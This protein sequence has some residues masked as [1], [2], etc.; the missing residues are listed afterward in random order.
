MSTG[1]QLRATMSPRN[2]LVRGAI[3]FVKAGLFILGSLI[4]VVLFIPLLV[5]A[6]GATV[7][8]LLWPLYLGA[9]LEY[10]FVPGD[11]VRSSQSIWPEWYLFAFAWIGLLVVGTIALR[12]YRRNVRFRRIRQAALENVAP[13]G[14]ET[15]DVTGI[16]APDLGA[17]VEIDPEEFDPIDGEELNAVDETRPKI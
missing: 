16:D 2:R 15:P 10:G 5:L 9:Y 17:I 6:S 3:E 8:A 7:L 12:R 4:L 11:P 1:T 13:E 14:V